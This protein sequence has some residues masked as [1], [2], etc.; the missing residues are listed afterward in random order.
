MTRLTY[1]DT[2]EYVRH[3]VGKVA[4]SVS[5]NRIGITAL[6]AAALLSGRKVD[7]TGRGLIVEV[8]PAAALCRWGFDPF[9]H[10]SQKVKLSYKGTKRI[11]QRRRLVEAIRLQT[12]WLRA[13]LDQ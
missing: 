13:S 12:P 9:E 7:R 1:R 2:D 10:E 6:K 8:Y 5:T 4:L 3:E 11:V